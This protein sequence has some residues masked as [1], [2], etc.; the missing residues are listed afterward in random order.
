MPEAS[1]FWD[2]TA[3]VYD[4]A[5]DDV[6]AN[7]LRVLIRERL[8]R[9]QDL[10]RTVEFGCG[11]GYYTPAL[12]ARSSGGVVATDISEKMLD[13]LRERI[14]GVPGI[15]AEY[16][17]CEETPFPDA[18]FDT[19]FFGLSFHFVDGDRTLAEMHRILRPGGRL[20]L[21][22]PTVEGLSLTEKIRGVVRNYRAFGKIRQPGTRLYTRKTV[23]SLLARAGF[24]PD[25]TELVTDPAH[26]GGFACIWVRALR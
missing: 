16:A 24:R 3:V 26:P 10:G 5:I 9:Q 4:D 17:D 22:I 23:G 19:A 7:D 12:A 20:I 15:V 14:R 8:D 25:E 18:S 1:Q 11:T 6:F 21:A 2:R 13:R